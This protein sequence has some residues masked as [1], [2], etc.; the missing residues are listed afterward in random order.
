M[1]NINQKITPV[2]FPHFH[3]INE[4]LY[5]E[6]IPLKILSEKLDTPLYVYSRASI[7]ESWNKY[8]KA[9]KDKNVLICYGMKANS[10][11]SIV[12]ELGFLGAGFDIVSGGELKK[13]IAAGINT[14]KVVFSGVGKKS[15]EIKIALEYGIKCFNIESESELRKISKISN[16]L[17]KNANI[18]IRINPNVDANTHP[19]ISTGL[20]ENKFGI[21]I[22][23]SLA[24]YKLASTL[25]NIK[26]VGIDCH[27]GS[28]I[29]E[30]AP[31]IDTIN[32]IINF[33]KKLHKININIEHID[34][35]G[36]LG[37]KYHNNDK[38]FNIEEL[39]VFFAAKLKENNLHNIQIIL[40]PGRSLVGN[41]G[42]LLSKVEYIKTTLTKNFAIIDAAMN[43][44]MRP[45]L[46]QAY[47]GILPVYN[48]NNN[49]QYY[50]IVGPVCESADWI[51]KNRLLSS[52]KE[53]DLI[54][55]E[56]A[57]AYCMTMA[58]NYNSRPKA[59]EIIVDKDKYYI[60]R[61]RESIEEIIQK[62][63]LIPIE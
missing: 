11:I 35:G 62:E 4:D 37:I 26:I 16:I 24:L 3:Y 5:V 32:K 48:K 46:Y 50:D 27:I 49:K 33:A 41:S 19:Y 10:N 52:L 39:L 54:A 1:T 63:L 34:L 60:I 18:S 59:A 8:A 57:G 36:G 13:V 51:A 23:E 55:I 15:W 53:G 22:E 38:I 14:N 20:K 28:Q 42:I 2:G 9:I 56:S 21:D 47:H 17:N 45:A 6:N 29:T 7:R 43:D 31:Y 40:E 12:K 58:S 30:L 25:P 44:I 61:Q